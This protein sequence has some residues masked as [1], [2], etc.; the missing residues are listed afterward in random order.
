MKFSAA[1]LVT[2]SLGLA[3]V[4]GPALADDITENWRLSGFESPESV[5]YD[6]ANDRIIIGNM[7]EMGPDAGTD[8]YLSLV[9]TDGELME[10]QWVTGL[11]DPKGMAIVGDSLFV[12][13]ANGLVEI[14]LADASISRT[15]ELDGAQFPNDVAADANGNIY[16]SDLMGEAIYKVKGDAVEQWLVDD[17]LTLPNGLY[18]DGDTLIVGS[19]G[20]DMDPATFQTAE[21]G[22]IILV[23]LDSKEVAPVE[24]A[25]GLGALDGVAMMGDMVLVNDNPTGTIYGWGEGDFPADDVT[26]LNPGA[27]DMSA[28]G[29]TIL[30]PQMMEGELVSMDFS[31]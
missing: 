27:A 3:A 2:T 25:S 28:Y 18:V 1:L 15:I 10:K 26:T 19:M 20:A 17:A 24:N 29:N 5:L 23:N 14:S 12:A 31:E 8:G 30:V 9:S 16:V 4:T 11:M 21:P 6:E 13:D 7:G 22:G